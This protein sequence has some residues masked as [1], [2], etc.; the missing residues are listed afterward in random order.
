MKKALGIAAIILLTMTSMA[1]NVLACKTSA[2]LQVHTQVLPFAKHAVLHQESNFTITEEDVNRGYVDIQKAMVISVKTNS[3]NGYMVLFS[4]GGDLF[5]RLTIL[6]SL[7]TYHLSASGG[8]IH[9]PSQGMRSETKDLSFRFNL[10]PETKPG[11]Y[12]WPV[13]VMVTAL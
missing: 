1:E 9:M 12:Q 3:S 5:D 11:T 7:N 2:L 4:V 8:E 13:G 10:S 6:D